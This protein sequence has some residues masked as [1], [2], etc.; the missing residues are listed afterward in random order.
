MKYLIKIIIAMIIMFLQSYL[1]FSQSYTLP[2][3][4]KYYG[5][6]QENDH[7][8]PD[9]YIPTKF[10]PI[11]WSEDGKLAYIIEPADEACGCYFFSIIIQDMNR[12]KII[13]QWNL[14]EEIEGHQDSLESIWKKNHKM[15]TDTL[16]NHFIHQNKN[17]TIKKGKK[18]SY[19][20]NS[21]NIKV[22]Q[23]REAR[24]DNYFNA[25]TYEKIIVE[26]NNNSSKRVYEKS[27]K[28]FSLSLSAD[29]VGHIKSPY[30]NRIALIYKKEIRGY[31]G[32]PNVIGF[33]L[34]GCDLETNF[35]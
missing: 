3:E 25:I 32:P 4:I 29:V 17:I 2:Q 13:W 26:K 16:K 21:F 1:A 8:A 35:K 6:V 14:N 11:G 33:K 5:E 15:F 22:I 28:E 20:K 31:E 23:K 7:N 12:D 30:E 9:F 27:T 18:Y 19:S 34:I 24:E 10:F